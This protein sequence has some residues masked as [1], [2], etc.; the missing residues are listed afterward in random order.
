M[1]SK[2]FNPALS[3]LGNIDYNDLS[4]M[5]KG[6]LDQ[7]YQNLSSLLG[8]GV[9]NKES[10]VLYVKGLEDENI[11]V[12]ML[13]NIFSNFGNIKKIIFIRRQAA[14][15]IEYETVEYATKAK[16]YL[17]NIVFMGKP[18]RI[19][20]SFH[21]IINLKNK[22]SGKDSSEE[23]F[24]G[25]P[26]TFRFKKTKLLSMNPPSSTLHVSNLPKEICSEEI[27]RNAFAPFGRIEAIQFKFMDNNRNMCLIRMAS[28]EESLN[29]MAH[30]HDLDLGGRPMQISFT[31]SKI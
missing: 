25:A 9:E 22:K 23:I 20:Y 16:D 2:K 21:P 24:L 7:I 15:L 30:L 3:G 28:M 6:A 14:A 4:T 12:Q 29:A 5:N 11:K 17:N 18:L 19:Y 13:Y 26:K 10:A 1:I 8:K 27:M 31:K